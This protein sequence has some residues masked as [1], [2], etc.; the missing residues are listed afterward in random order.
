MTT[1]YTKISQN[2]LE[3]LKNLNAGEWIL[4]SGELITIRDSSQTMLIEY[5]NKEGKLP[6]QINN[7]I[8]IYAAPTDDIDNTVIGPT[9]SKRMDDHLDFLLDM[10]VAATIGKGDRTKAAISLIQKYKTPY[11]VLMSGVS[12][13][14]SSFFSERK[15]LA[16]EELGP[17][18][19][20]LF[21]ASDLPLLMAIDSK[22]ESIFS[23]Y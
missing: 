22:G 2:S 16:F 8:I 21:T 13:Y 4:Y 12:A 10:G 9:T 11:M 20:H 15:I 5:Y 18:A 7:K 17:E 3:E 14:L 23:N 6:F 1:K 19:I